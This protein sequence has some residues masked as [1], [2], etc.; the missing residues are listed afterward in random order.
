VGRIQGEKFE[1]GCV[2]TLLVLARGE[3]LGLS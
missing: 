3:S 1:G 2:T